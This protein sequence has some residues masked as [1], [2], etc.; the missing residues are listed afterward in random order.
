MKK[1]FKPQRKNIIFIFQ[2]CMK[3]IFIECLP[4]RVREFS[5]FTMSGRT[6]DETGNALRQQ[7]HSTEDGRAIRL[8]KARQQIQQQ[9]EAAR[10]KVDSKRRTISTVDARFGGSGAEKLEEQFRI[11]TVGLVSV[12]EFREKRRK[13]DELIEQENYSV[14]KMKNKEKKKKQVK[15]NNLSFADDEAISIN[16]GDSPDSLTTNLRKKNLGKD[17]SVNTEFLRDPERESQLLA[18]KN[19][20]IEEFKNAQEVEKQQLLEVTYSYWDGSGHRRSIQIEKGMTVGEF[21]DK[22]RHSLRKEFPELSTVGSENLMY[23]KEDLILPHSV[24]FY[25]LIQYRA[26]GKSGPLFNFDVHDDVRLVDDH[27]VEKDESHAGKIVERKWYDRNKHIFPASRW[28]IY[29]PSR[30]FDKYTIRGNTEETPA[31]I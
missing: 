13:I 25:D 2:L 16:D 21:L 9:A 11:E 7:I 27:R 20:L 19:E 15:T 14:S 1:K 18:R 8:L 31:K 22:C 5:N 28:E 23:I 3:R 30:T 6:L 10:E 17:P 29:D 24:T 4:I 12:D 26:R